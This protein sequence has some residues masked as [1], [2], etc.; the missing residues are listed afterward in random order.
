[1]LGNPDPAC[2][3]NLARISPARLPRKAAGMECEST[4]PADKEIPHPPPPP[5]SLCMAAGL[6]LEPPAGPWVHGQSSIC[7]H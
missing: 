2:T 4:R 6:V 5:P 7:R 1:M 3:A